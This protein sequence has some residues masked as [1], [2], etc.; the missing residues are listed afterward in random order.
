MVARTT[1]IVTATAFPPVSSL[2]DGG[3]PRSVLVFH[4]VWR[5]STRQERVAAGTYS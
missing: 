4:L 5:P 3:D 2:T 1:K